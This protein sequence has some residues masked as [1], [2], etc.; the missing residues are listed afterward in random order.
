VATVSI[1]VPGAQ[2]LHGF[3]LTARAGDADL[4]WLDQVVIAG[5]EPVQIQLPVAF[6]DPTGQYQ[7]MALELFS[8]KSFQAALQVR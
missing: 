3:K 4:D 5:A 2:G 8:R 6:N 1:A 7:I